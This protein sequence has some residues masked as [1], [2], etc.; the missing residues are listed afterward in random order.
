MSLSIISPMPA[1]E[2][3]QQPL[4]LLSALRALLVPPVPRRTTR[5]TQARAP[6]S[7][8]GLAAALTAL[9]AAAPAQ[10]VDFGPFS[11]TGFVKLGLT[12]TTNVCEDCQRD[13]DAT[14]HRVW[15]DDIVFG[16]A[17]GTRES[18]VSLVQ[19]YLSYKQ[20]IG[21]GWEVF[22]LLSQRWR[23]GR[24]DLPGWYYE[25]NVGVAHEDWGRLTLGA[26]TTRSWS[27]A[28]F[29]YSF[30]AMGSDF[31]GG[32]NGANTVWSDSGAGYGL[33]SRAVRYMSR[34]VG[35][36][37][38]DVLF[39][40]T[41]DMGKSGWKKNKPQFLELY[42]KY[43]GR[44]MLVDVVVQS[45]KNGEPVA[46]GKAPFG[47]LT[48]FPVD[49]P[50]LGESSQGIFMVMVRRMLD[51][52]TEVSAGVRF[53]RWSGA[54]AVQTTFGPLGQWNNMFNVNWGG[55]DANGIANPGFAARSTDF[56]L[57]ARYRVTDKLTA[58][59]GLVHLGKASTD[60]PRERGQ[61]N[62]LTSASLSLSYTVNPFI[63]VGVTGAAYEFG[64]VGQAPLSIPAHNA[65][66][67]I[68]SRV[69]KRGNSIGINADFTF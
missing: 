12:S 25:R 67:G 1:P 4:P 65:L 58:G 31:W 49:D 16:K 52:K 32:G 13:P 54:Y 41:Y 45:A 61:S 59:A 17:F 53:N 47:G 35:L 43:I 40:A 66:T 60:N 39:E 19:P 26:M 15:A 34:P 62:T 50:L 14:R 37:G 9:L 36:F 8:L 21:R 69:A 3:L 30:K 18:D 22:G 10:A 64:R 24:L 33:L 6:L 11:L 46:W 5:P 68:D 29:P 57:G 44:N 38:G 7:T 51:N 56:M 63:Q 55:V 20:D 23:D 42:A 27:S 28:D 2:P 48:P